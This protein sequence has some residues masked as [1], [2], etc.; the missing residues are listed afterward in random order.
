M[1]HMAVRQEM[2]LSQSETD[3]M[4][5]LFFD[6]QCTTWEVGLLNLEVVWDSGCPCTINSTLILPQLVAD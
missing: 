1:G 4:D 5:N 6:A 3:N 2:K